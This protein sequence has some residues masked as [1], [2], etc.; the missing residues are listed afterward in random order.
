VTFGLSRL[1]GCCSTARLRTLRQRRAGR[2]GHRTSSQSQAKVLPTAGKDAAP[3]LPGKGNSRPAAG[4]EIAKAVPSSFAALPWQRR[5]VQGLPA[6][7]QTRS[8][9]ASPSAQLLAVLTQAKYALAARVLEC[10]FGSYHVPDGLHVCPDAQA[11]SDK[12]RL[13]PCTGPGRRA[14]SPCVGRGGGQAIARGLSALEHSAF[15]T[16]KAALRC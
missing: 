12:S 7:R 14:S 6:S 15:V 5:S 16:E 10:L 1:P 13:P 2:G 9:T 11:V 8:G 4:V 3:A